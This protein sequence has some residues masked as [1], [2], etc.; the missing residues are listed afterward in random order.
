MK[1]RNTFTAQDPQ[2]YHRI[3]IVYASDVLLARLVLNKYP[4]LKT[5]LITSLDHSIWFHHP[6]QADQWYLYVAEVECAADGRSLTGC[7]LAHK[8]L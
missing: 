7:R 4:S 6:V 2:N 8:F 5:D 3:A 1:G